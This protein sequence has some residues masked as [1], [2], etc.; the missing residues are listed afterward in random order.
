[1]LQEPVTNL[2]QCFSARSAGLLQEKPVMQSGGMFLL[3]IPL[4]YGLHLPALPA[5]KIR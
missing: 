5:A 3:L 4:L 1:M 2:H